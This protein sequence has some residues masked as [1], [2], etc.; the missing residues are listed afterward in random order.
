MKHR[1]QQNEHEEMLCAPFG[2]NHMVT[3]DTRVPLVVLIDL[4]LPEM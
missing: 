4:I 3:Y 2:G 1:K